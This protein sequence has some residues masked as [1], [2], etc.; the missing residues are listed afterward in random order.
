MT[1]KDIKISKSMI[2]VQNALWIRPVG[3]LSFKIYY[4]HG[5]NWTEMNVNGSAPEP[6]GYDK[7]EEQIEELENDVSSI[8]KR[9]GSL[10]GLKSSLD[11]LANKVDTIAKVAYE[12][13]VDGYTSLMTEYMWFDAPTIPVPKAGTDIPYN[14]LPEYNVTEE[15]LD[16]IAKEEYIAVSMYKNRIVENHT[17]LTKV[18]FNVTVNKENDEWTSIVLLENSIDLGVYLDRYTITRREGYIPSTQGKVYIYDIAL[19]RVRPTPPEPYDPDN[20]GGGG[21]SIVTPGISEDPDGP[22]DIPPFNP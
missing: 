12:G 11:A 14:N 20:G 2:P 19:S 21:T 8:S 18:I 3:G 10:E 9:L 7:M 1:L 6:E 22:I 17:E 15:L 13:R 16:I 4:P 5:G